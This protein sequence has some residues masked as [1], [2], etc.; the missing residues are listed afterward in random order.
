MKLSGM[1]FFQIASQRMQWLGERQ[2]VISENIANADTPDYKAKD[3]SPFEQMLEGGERTS[4]L[5]TTHANHI[6]GAPSPAAGVSVEGDP[7]AWETS[8]DGNTV[9]LE[10]QTIK[11]AEISEHYRLAAQLYRK[12]HDLLTLAVTGVR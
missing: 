6:Q 8:L 10:Q 3:I 1:A 11:A 2:V 7:E 9:S 5:R 4:G 12:G